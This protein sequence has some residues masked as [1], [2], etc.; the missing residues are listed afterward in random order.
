MQAPALRAQAPLLSWQVRAQCF[1]SLSYRPRQFFD[2]TPAASASMHIQMMSSLALLSPIHTHALTATLGVVVSRGA[3]AASTTAVFPCLLAHT[4]RER[5]GSPPSTQGLRHLLPPTAWLC[6]TCT[7]ALNN[8]RRQDRHDMRRKFGDVV[9]HAH[10]QP[11][12][13]GTI[14]RD[15]SHC[16]PAALRL[17]RRRL[18]CQVLRHV[19][20]CVS[21]FPIVFA[22]VDAFAPSECCGAPSTS[23]ACMSA[24]LC[25][26]R[27][28]G[29]PS[30]LL[31]H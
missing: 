9:R 15:L 1:R 25:P 30:P 18:A 8:C 22:A 19:G 27:P 26:C 17:C 2:G 3:R 24:R 6:R 4:V 14:T 7:L 23:T 20:A 28:L 10:Q 21:R 13:C 11:R 16:M 31:P 5:E 12:A 29:A